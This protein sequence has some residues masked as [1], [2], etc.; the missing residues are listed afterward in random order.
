MRRLKRLAVDVGHFEDDE[1]ESLRSPPQSIH[2]HTDF[3]L[4]GN[5]MSARSFVYTT[6][7]II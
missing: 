5:G 3:T 7:N 6:N 1:D 2:R 4:R